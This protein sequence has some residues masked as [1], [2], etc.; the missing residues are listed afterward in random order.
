MTQSLCTRQR[1]AGPRIED[2]NVGFAKVS[3]VTGTERQGM[4]LR[5]RGDKVWRSIP[6][7][8]SASVTLLRKK[9]SATCASDH[10]F[11]RRLGRGLRK[12]PHL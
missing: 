6:K 1:S 9:L 11:T 4:H 12:V 8:I 10:A 2:L 7:R 5:G 3:L